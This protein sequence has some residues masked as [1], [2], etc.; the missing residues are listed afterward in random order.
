[1]IIGEVDEC[2]YRRMDKREERKIEGYEG[3]YIEREKERP[4]PKS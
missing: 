1:M 2:A 4:N 3:R